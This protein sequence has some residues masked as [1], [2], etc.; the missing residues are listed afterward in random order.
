LLQV[1]VVVLIILVEEQE[2][3]VLEQVVFLFVEQL[4]IQLQ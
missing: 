3:E 1:E 4:H 2:Q